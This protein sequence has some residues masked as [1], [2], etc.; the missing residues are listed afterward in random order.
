L[1]PSTVLI[2]AGAAVVSA[3]PPAV[4]AWALLA[5][6]HGDLTGAGLTAVAVALGLVLA[7]LLG[8][9]LLLLGRSWLTLVLI[10]GALAGCAVAAYVAG[11]WAA[12]VSTFWLV[13]WLLPGL[14]AVLAG[15]PV[16]RRWVSA[17]RAGPAR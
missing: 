3:L 15:L 7:L 17:R 4:Y 10:A 8:A 16:A 9:V 12:E 2:A 11:D 13:A 14:T 1:P 6:S 5:L